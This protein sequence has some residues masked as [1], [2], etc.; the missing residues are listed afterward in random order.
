MW[1]APT[2]PEA[3]RTLGT[4]SSLPEEYGA[5]VL[6]IAQD[7]RLVGVQRKEL[8]DLI[9]SV[10][11]GRLAREASKM[12]RLQLAVLVVE[13]EVAWTRDGVMMD[14]YRRW[15][16]SQHRRLLYTIRSKGIWVV[17][18]TSLTETVNAIED[19]KA[20]A[21]KAEHLSLVRRPAAPSP[22]G[23][24]GTRDWQ[25]WV[26]QGLPGVGPGLAEAIITHFEGQMP[27]GWIVTED[28]LAKVPGLGPKRLKALMDCLPVIE[29]VGSR[30]DA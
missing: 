3:L 24:P 15:S 14:Q 13:G 7:K 2:E 26:L 11:D 9:S 29:A 21:E 1:V 4:S 28:E 8:N 17:E 10:H 23:K 12:G 18:T 30:T 20:W 6:F 16:R 5:D 19:L 22:W 27:V 25:L